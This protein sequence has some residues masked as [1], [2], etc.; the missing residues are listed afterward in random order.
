VGLFER[1]TLQAR[2]K[3]KWSHRPSSL[4]PR[5]EVR[6]RGS[7]SLGA[8]AKSKPLIRR[9]APPSPS[10]EKNSVRPG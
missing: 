7:A 6:V 5:G 9:F 3:F 2:V 4:S 1:R 8:A 10:G